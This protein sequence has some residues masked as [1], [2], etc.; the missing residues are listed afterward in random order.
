M[1]LALIAGLV[2]VQ[3]GIPEQQLSGNHKWTEAEQVTFIT[4]Y[5]DHSFTKEGGPQYAFHRW[6]ITRDGALL[7]TWQTGLSRFTKI[8]GP[9]VYEGMNWNNNPLRMEKQH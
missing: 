9:G 2:V 6:E 7:I 8:V 3:S 1:L 4:L 5:P